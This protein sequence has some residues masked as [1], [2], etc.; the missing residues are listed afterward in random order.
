MLHRSGQAALLLIAIAA[1]PLP[2]QPSPQR[3]AAL[4]SRTVTFLA[5]FVQPVAGAPVTATYS[6]EVE[7]PMAAGGTETLHSITQV[8][9]DSQGRVRHELHEYV[10]E[11]QK[12]ARPPFAV[13]LTDPVARLSHILD[14]VSRTDT[15]LWFHPSHANLSTPGAVVEDLGTKT[16]DG[17]AVSGERRT[18]I[19]VSEPAA[20]PLRKVDEVWSSKEL[21]LRVSEQ[22]T[23]FS[24]MVM[25]VTLVHVDRGEPDTALFKVP[26]G[27]HAP[28]RGPRPALGASPIAPP[29]QDESGPEGCCI[30]PGISR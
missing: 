13:I 4:H 19:D 11:S 16:I 9:R 7:R 3:S 29:D 12:A 5:P 27:F 8:A 26:K 14:I 28:S 23:S 17:F 6:I 1:L 20:Q 15:R 30:V 21:Q 25:R 10:P 18:W 2:A 22:R 24:G